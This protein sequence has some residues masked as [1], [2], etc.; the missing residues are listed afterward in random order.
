MVELRFRIDHYLAKAAEAMENARRATDED[1][2]KNYLLTAQSWAALARQA[3][4]LER[5][6]K[7]QE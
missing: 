3:E 4:E 7:E 6:N 5:Y 1:S 2:R